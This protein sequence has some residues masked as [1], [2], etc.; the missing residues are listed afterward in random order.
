MSNVLDSLFRFGKPNEAHVW[1]LEMASLAPEL[2]RLRTYLSENELEKAGRFRFERHRNHYLISHGWM[3]EVLSRYLLVAPSTLRFELGPKGKP[4]L[5]GP[6]GPRKVLFNLS[7]CEG[8]AVLAI[9][10]DARVGIDVER[11]RPLADAQLLVDRFF[12]KREADQFRHAGPETIDLAF[13]NLWTRKEAWLKATG[14]GITHLLGQVEVGFF[15]G[16][17]ERLI[18]LPPGYGA[19]AAWSLC[20][21]NPLPGYVGALA[22]EARDAKPIVR[23]W[24]STTAKGQG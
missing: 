14:E 11:V 7:H 23:S 5:A 10:P 20:S 12:S 13:F 1:V 4:S 22:I 6:T 18:E 3:R 19:A 21:F 2:H 24:D 16:E 8:V 17:P 9:S 15:P